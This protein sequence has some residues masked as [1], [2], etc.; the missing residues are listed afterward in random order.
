MLSV[1]MKLVFT[2][3]GGGFDIPNN[4]DAP[5][6]VMPQ[7]GTTLD[8][9]GNDVDPCMSICTPDTSTEG[10]VQKRNSCGEFHV[11]RCFYTP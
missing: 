3:A 10:P 5:L 2:V 6:D 7:S 8:P 9:P 4:S 11:L 1:V